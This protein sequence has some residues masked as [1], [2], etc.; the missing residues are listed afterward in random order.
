M[1][2]PLSE[3]HFEDW[4]GPCRRGKVRDTYDLGDRLLMIASDRISAFDVVMSEPIPDK[5]RVLTAMSLFWFNL[6]GDVVPN[7]LISANLNDFALLSEDYGRMLDGR[8]MLVKKCTPLPIEAIVR[9][10]ISGS[11][12]EDYKQTGAVCGIPLPR[13]LSE[14]DRLSEPIFTPSTKEEQGLHDENISFTTMVNIIGRNLAERI[15]DISLMLYNQ[16]HAYAFKSGI[17]IAD[18]KFEFGLDKNGILT[19]IDEVLTPDSSRFWPSATHKPGGPQKSYDK[20]YLRDYLKSLGWN[21]KPP[22]PPLPQEVIDNTRAK[23]IEALV[24]LTGQGLS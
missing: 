10:Y 23:Y 14:S 16:A 1:S 21:K 6:L 24:S 2:G 15:Q 13:F 17:I 12:W 7:H 18:T 22:P 5:G 8:S 3:T 4:L 20:Q 11:A 9:G 19:L